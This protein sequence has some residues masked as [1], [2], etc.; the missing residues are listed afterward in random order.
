MSEVSEVSEVSA[1]TTVTIINRTQAEITLCTDIVKT[2]KGKSTE[3]ARTVVEPAPIKFKRKSRLVGESQ[4]L[5]GR[6]ITIPGMKKGSF[7]THPVTMAKAD[8]ERLSEQ[9][10]VKALIEGGKL[11]VS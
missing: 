6:H 2:T 11:E 9:P 1:A 8:W 10:I 7:Q 3:P 5:E 4:E